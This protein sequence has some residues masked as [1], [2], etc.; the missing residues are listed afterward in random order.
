MPKGNLMDE[1]TYELIC[2]D[3]SSEYTIVQRVEID[4][5]DE[6]PVYCPYCGAGVDVSELDEEIDKYLDGDDLDE[7]DFDVD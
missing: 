5:V 4:S 1:I 2:D 7:L 3:C 6:L